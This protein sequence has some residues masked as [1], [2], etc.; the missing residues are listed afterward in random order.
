MNKILKKNNRFVIS[1]QKNIKYKKSR[2]LNGSIFLKYC[3]TRGL[4]P[5]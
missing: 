3:I 1:C 4:T 2:N 5:C